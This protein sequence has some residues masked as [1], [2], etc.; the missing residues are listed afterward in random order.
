ML[1]ASLIPGAMATGVSIIISYPMDTVKTRLQTGMYKGILNCISQTIKTDGV[2]GLYR[3]VSSPLT[4]LVLKRSIQ[5]KIYEEMNG[6]TN[7]WISGCVAAMALSPFGCPVNVV[8]VRMQDSKKDRYKN[9]I[10]CIKDIW[11]TEGARGFFKGFKTNLFKDMM[12]GTLYLGSY[13]V[14]KDSFETMQKRLDKNIY[15]YDFLVSSKGCNF[16]AGG[17]AGTFAWMILMPVDMVKTTYQSG[18]SIDF[19]ISNINKNGI[20]VLWRGVIP[21]LLRVFPSSAS[22]MLTYEYVK[23]AMIT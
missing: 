4:T 3:G 7:S 22:S 14:I 15:C 21:V 9:M 6:K 11:K 16:F 12:F 23:E 1:L 2:L 10:E 18:R 17:L 19:V 5:F 13:G 20:F 8:K